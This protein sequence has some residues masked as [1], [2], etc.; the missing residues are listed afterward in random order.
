MVASPTW[1]RITILLRQAPWHTKT[2]TSLP[3]MGELCGAE[4]Y[5][6]MFV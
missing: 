3:R 1:T 6:A 5:R 2:V 4:L